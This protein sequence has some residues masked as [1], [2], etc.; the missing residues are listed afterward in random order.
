VVAICIE[1]N[2]RTN[3]KQLQYHHFVH[4]GSDDFN[5]LLDHAASIL[6][7]SQLG[8]LLLDYAKHHID[9]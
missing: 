8:D 1:H 4:L 9:L 6:V 7:E 3:S 5:G 2:A